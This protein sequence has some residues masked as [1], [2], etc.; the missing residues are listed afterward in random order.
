MI[1][2]ASGSSVM[3]MGYMSIDLVNVLLCCHD[4]ESGCWYPPCKTDLKQVSSGNG[5][6]MRGLLVR[7][8]HCRCDWL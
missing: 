5:S 7:D 2:F 3:K 8:F 4:R 1:T 6:W